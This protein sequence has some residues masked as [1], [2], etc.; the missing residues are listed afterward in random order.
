M[1]I[2]IITTGSSDIQL[3]TDKNWNHTHRQIRNQKYNNHDFKPQRPNNADENES[4]QVPARVMGIVYGEHLLNEHYDDLDFPIFDT[5]SAKLQALGT[6]PDKVIVI[7]TDQSSIFEEQDKRKKQCPYWQD[8]CTLEPIITKYF[9]N[10]QKKFEK[11]GQVEY[12]YLQ[13]TSKQEGLDNWDSTLTLVK[14]SLADLKLEEDPTIYV[15]HQAGTPAISSAIQ[16][17]TLAKFGNQVQFLVSSEYEKSIAYTIPSPKYLWAMKLQEVIAL[18][19]RHDYDGMKDILEPY[20]RKKDDPVVTRINHLLEIAIQWNYANFQKF[21][22]DFA[23]VMGDVANERLKTWWWTGYEAAYLAV[24][25]LEQGNTVE[26][27]FHSFRAVE[28]TI[29]EWAIN[30]Y[31]RHTDENEHG[32]KLK[33]SILKELP[34]YLNHLS[35]KQQKSFQHYQNIGL[36]SN[37]LFKLLQTARPEYKT[38]PYIKIVWDDAQEERNAQFHRLLGLTKAEVFDSWNASNQKDWEKKLLGCLEFI[39]KE[40][41][42]SLKDT[43][44]M[45]QVHEELR[46]SLKE[47]QP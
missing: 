24:V 25:R 37:A 21:A 47:Y 15:S 34:Q 39:S 23:K 28:G 10:L 11:I 45:S 33:Y 44:L 14:N 35:D 7:F 27:L 26:A 5:L 32:W 36:F 4:F 9:E 17:M 16:F 19:E 2:W 13:P 40:R 46:N 1:N 38:H 6:L 8:T 43:S 3:K 29:L 31:P 42:T 41:F 30:K 18:L 12:K 20:L 22:E